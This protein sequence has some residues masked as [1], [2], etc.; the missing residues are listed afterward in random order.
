MRPNTLCSVRVL[1][2]HG[3]LDS[4]LQTIYRAA[5][6]AKLTYASSDWISFS[7]ANDRQKIAAFIRHS[8]R[9]IASTQVNLTTSV[10]LCD[11]ADTQLLAKIL[12]NPHH[13]LQTLL[14][15]PADRHYN[16]R[17]RLHKIGSFLAA[18]RISLIVIL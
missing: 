10:S 7:T 14:P 11:T 6:A 13:V 8:K 16:L 2:A 5:A 4:A 9:T 18:C 17:D 15:P 1:R 3:L 12:H